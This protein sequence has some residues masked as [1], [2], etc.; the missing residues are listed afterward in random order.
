MSLTEAQSMCSCDLVNENFDWVNT[1]DSLE[2]FDT[3][4]VLKLSKNKSC[5]FKGLEL[6]LKLFIHQKKFESAFKVI[7]KLE[8]ILSE[9][10]CKDEFLFNIYI[11]KADYYKALNNYEKLSEFAFKCLKEAERL[12][13][14]N[15]EIEAIKQIVHLFTRMDEDL[16][17]WDYIKR[18]QKLIFNQKE[19]LESIVNYRWLAYEYENKYTTTGRKTLIDSGFAFAKK[20]KVGAFKYKNYDELAKLYRAF[21]SF[22]YH[23]GELDKA[24]QYIDTAIFYA[25]QIKGDKNLSGL[26]LSKAWDHLDLGEKEEAVKWMDTVMAIDK[27]NDI[28]GVMMEYLDASDLYE[29]SDRLDKAYSAF[30][31]YAKMKDSIMNRERVE[32]INELETKYKTELKD[33]KIKRQGVWLVI[34][35]LVIVLIL[36]IGTIFQLKRTKQKNQALKEAYEKQV[37]LEKELTA[38]RENIAQDFHDDLGNRLAR[39]SLLSSLVNKEVSNKEEKLRSKVKQIT[40]DANDLYLGT[41]DFIFSLKENSDFVEELVTYLSDFGENYFSKTNIKFE[42]EK[43]IDVNDKLPYYWS[44][45]LIYIFKEAMTNALK[46]ARCNYVSLKFIYK[47]NELEIMCTDNGIGIAQQDLNSSNG[48]SNMKERAHKIGGFL[49]IETKEKEGTKIIFKGKTT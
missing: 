13:D 21:E 25:K 15:K 33:A 49:H 24:L 17:N 29:Q 47:K 3:S 16:K 22:S 6:E 12:N 8:N 7:N 36:F 28:V 34:A 10:D 37:A 45:Q 9:I 31:T 35:S 5:E 23:K 48:L 40:D 18:A 39:I 26:Y 46:Y 41:R 30:K 14:P 44:K 2:V 1:R 32:V 4:K 43:H 42:L 19:S 11:Q 38:V 20:A 27:S